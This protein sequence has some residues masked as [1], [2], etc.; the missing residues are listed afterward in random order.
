[1]QVGS[2]AGAAHLLNNNTGVQR[3]ALLDQKSSLE[4]KV[5]SVLDFDFQYK[6]ELWKHVF[7]ILYYTVCFYAGKMNY[8]N[9]IVEVSE[10]LPEGL[11]IVPVVR[12][13]L[14]WAIRTF[15]LHFV[16][17]NGKCGGAEHLCSSHHPC[18][19]SCCWEALRA[20][21]AKP[22]CQVSH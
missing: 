6:L 1:M 22:L 8:S 10:K 15:W 13:Y 4:N 21:I 2:L 18:D 16:W 12:M 20:L 14:C 5:K 7:K 11:K 19:I 9:I 17:T 3:C